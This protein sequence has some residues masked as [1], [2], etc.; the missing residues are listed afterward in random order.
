MWREDNVAGN[1]GKLFIVQ[2]HFNKLSYF[3]L[4][5]DSGKKEIKNKREGKNKEKKEKK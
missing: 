3:Q 4:K 2:N 5:K 1:G